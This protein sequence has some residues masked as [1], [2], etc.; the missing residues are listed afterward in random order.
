MNIALLRCGLAVG[1]QYLL[2]VQGRRTGLPRSTPVSIATIGSERFI[3]A[4]F[5]HAA[6]VANVRAAGA[7]TLSRGRGS[8][9]EA[10][11]LTE[12]AVDDRGPVLRAFLEQVRGAFGSSTAGRPMRSSRRPS[13]TLSS[14]FRCPLRTS[15]QGVRF[16]RVGR[17]P[18]S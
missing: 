9:G 18:Y 10:V 5:E 2:T 15:P 8:R 17:F 3:V 6:W 14:G 1:S 13:D 4:A 12:L 7:G 16:D 11:L